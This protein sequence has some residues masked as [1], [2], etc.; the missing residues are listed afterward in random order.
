MALG[1]LGGATNTIVALSVAFIRDGTIVLFPWA[2]VAQAMVL[3]VAFGL[4]SQTLTFRRGATPVNQ[5]TAHRDGSLY[6]TAFA[7]LQQSKAY[8]CTLVFRAEIRI[9]KSILFALRKSFSGYTAWMPGWS[10]SDGR[11][12][13]IRPVTRKE[14]MRGGRSCA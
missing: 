11:I 12:A 4:I 13:P 5:V 7:A 1:L 2:L 9:A 3:P 6:I 14:R 10:P 8:Q